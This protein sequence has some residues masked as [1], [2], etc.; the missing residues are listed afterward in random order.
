M[1]RK[2]RFTSQKFSVVL[3]DNKHTH[4]LDFNDVFDTQN[5][6]GKFIL[7]HHTL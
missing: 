6:L 7:V 1:I 2:N 3:N 4:L 5:N